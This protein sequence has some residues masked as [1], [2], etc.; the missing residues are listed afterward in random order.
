MDDDLLM[1][2]GIQHFM[3]CP[4]QWAL[5]HVEQQWA[6]N[7]LTTEGSL[8]HQR[9]DDPLARQIN[10]GVLTLRRVPLI[11]HR[12]RLSGF[13]DAVECRSVAEGEPGAVRLSGRDG[14]WSVLPVEY[15]H[16]REKAD[17]T[18]EV[19]LCA[20][21]MALEEMNGASVRRGAI[22]YWQ[23]RKRVYV[24][25]TD[26]LRGKTE[27]LAAQMWELMAEG[28]TPPPVKTPK[29]GRCS[30]RDICMP[31]ETAGLSAKTYLKRT[32]YAE[33]A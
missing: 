7:A 15:K 29:C 2:S 5:I 19:Q 8:L 3:F 20:Q 17:E 31:E 6:D 1:L 21:C 22:F 16:G 30:L 10:N 9:V 32:L 14:W 13:S 24:D 11:S 18:D 25:M 33:D 26:A 27:S 28:R 23:T 12:L 4:R